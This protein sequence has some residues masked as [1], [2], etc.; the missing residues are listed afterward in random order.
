MTD[1]RAEI[2]TIVK[3][4][5]S[6]PQDVVEEVQARIEPLIFEDL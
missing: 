5:E 4:V 6:V 2:D 1:I 3:F